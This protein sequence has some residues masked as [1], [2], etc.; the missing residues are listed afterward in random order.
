MGCE[1][2]I[3]SIRTL[4]EQIEE[5]E[6][7]VIKLKRARN[8]LL[9]IST[10]VPPEI[11]GYIFV[12]ILVREGGHSVYIWHFGGLQEDS[13]NFL[14]VCHH[15]FEVASRTP[16]LWSFWG[17]TLQDW[18]KRHHRSK[19]T[20]LDLVLDEYES[21][22]G[23]R[24]HGSLQDAVRSRVMQDAIRQVHLRSYNRQTLTSIISS[25]TPAGGGGQNKNIESMAL[26]NDGP[27]TINVSNFFAQSRL[28]G[29]RLLDLCGN[30]WIPQWDHL[31]PRTTLLTSL[32]LDVNISSP[33]PLI[34]AAQLFSILVSNPN[35]QE[36]LLADAALPNDIDASTSK[37]QLRRLK[38]L[39]LTGESCHL[40]QLLH[41]LILSEA[42]DDLYLTGSDPTME[43]ISQTLAQYMRDYFQRDPRFQDRLGVSSSSSH[44][45][46][47]ISIALVCA[48]TN[49][50]V[51]EPPRVSLAAIP[52]P[53][54]PERL[55][56]DLITLI[57]RQRV[58]FFDAG[59]DVK[60]PEELFLM[61]PN[62]EKLHLS[63]QALSEGFLQPNPDGPH[64]NTKLLPSLRSLRLGVSNDDDWGLLKTYLVHQTSEN[65]PISL[66]VTGDIPQRCP[67]VV[68]EIRDLVEEFT[69]CQISEAG[70]DE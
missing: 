3:D 22:P 46:I 31:I 66:Q 37:V 61:M 19:S 43:V 4:E 25:L 39:L 42:L 38:V 7:D 8:S 24:F 27:S 12:W 48:Q 62:I 16:E 1:T 44:G 15:W 70:D 64:A 23:V 53:L 30:F 18:E 33:S 67:G 14:L 49:A 68:S 65:Q 32:S 69:C 35:L 58:V 11:L 21:Y 28:S 54:L 26:Q 10:H 45:S 56:V 13:Y 6:G 5:G 40:L 60:L 50:P 9:N 20:P 36:L 2:N 52:E 41:H 47:S 29:L 59:L 63:N 34:T 57:P 51:Q 55:L 17:N